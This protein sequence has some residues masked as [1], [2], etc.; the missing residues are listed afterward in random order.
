MPLPHGRGSPRI[1]PRRRRWHRTTSVVSGVSAHGQQGRR[2]NRACLQG[3]SLL[4]QQLM[5]VLRFTPLTQ[6]RLEVQDH[7][8]CSRQLCIIHRGVAPSVLEL[9]TGVGLLQQHLRGHQGGKGDKHVLPMVRA[10]TTGDCPR[11][12]ADWELP[13]KT[14]HRQSLIKPGLRN[15]GQDTLNET[16][17]RQG[18]DT[19]PGNKCRYVSPGM[20]GN[21][22]L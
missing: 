17:T 10:E 19:R 18:Q 20:Y 21:K 5:P 16:G 12:E 3:A 6:R 15:R 4:G 13:R 9:H 14:V 7:W 2:R 22:W 1:L 8:L 11:A